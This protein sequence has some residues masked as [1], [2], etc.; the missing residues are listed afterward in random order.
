MVG[1]ART[2]RAVSLAVALGLA[3]PLISFAADPAAA[4][5]SQT[6]TVTGAA[7]PWTVPAGVTEIEVHAWGAQ[8]GGTYGGLGGYVRATMTVTPGEVLHVYVGGAGSDTSGAGGWNGGG[9]GAT[10][11]SP[12]GAGGGG[13]T[14]VRVTPHTLT[15]RAVV[16]GGGGGAAANAT[17]AFGA[18]GAGGGNDGGFGAA[19]T[20]GAA[21]GAPGTQMGGYQLGIGGSGWCNP[22]GGG[23]G[24]GYWGG[25]GGQDGS[26]FF[27]AGG[28]GGSGHVAPTEATPVRMLA[29]NRQGDGRVEIVWPP[30]PY[31]VP[32]SHTGSQAFTATS[33]SQYWIVP[34]D[35]TAITVEGWGA[36]GGGLH[37][38]L[39]GYAKATL[40]V[41]PGQTMQ[42]NV[43][44]AGLGDGTG[45]FNGGGAGG[46]NA[47]DPPGAGGGGA[48]D[49][50]FGGIT[51]EARQF[52]VGG[53]GGASGDANAVHGSGGV[54]GGIVGGDGAVGSPGSSDPGAG[55]GQLGGGAQGMGG[56]GAC[57]WS[58]PGGGGGGWFGGGGGE[59]F[60]APISSGGGGGSAYVAASTG[61]LIETLPGVRQG[62]GRI[63]LSWPP[64]PAVGVGAPAADSAAFAY[65]G[66]PSYWTVPAGVTAV[67]V[68]LWGA[69]G[70]GAHGGEGGH[71][72]A[73]VAVQ[74]GQ[75]LQVNV[76]GAGST[77]AGGWNGGGP[78]DHLGDPSVFPS[79]GGGA[80]DIRIGG[81]TLD[82]RHVV[83]GGGGGMAAGATSASGFGG[84]GGGISGG[85]GDPGS[86]GLVEPS[87]PGTQTSGWIPGQ[88]APNSVYC[89]D[90][91]GGAGGGGYWG[92]R[93][94]GEYGANIGA[95][96]GGGSGFV[97]PAAVGEQES[98]VR[99]GNGAA[100]ISW[101]VTLETAPTFG[102]DSYGEIV[103]G[104]HTGSGNVVESVVDVTIPT[105]GPT[106][107]MARTYNSL[108]TKVGPFGRGWTFGYETKLTDNGATVTVTNGDGR[109]DTF[110]LQPDGSYR[111]PYSYVLTLTDTGPGWRLQDKD[112]SAQLFDGAGRLTAIEDRYGRRVDL[113]YNVDEL[114]AVTDVASGRALSFEWTSGRIT[115]VRTSTVTVNGVTAQLLWRYAY[116]NGLLSK[117]CDARYPV[118]SGEKCTLYSYSNDRLS[119]I[120]TPRGN[121]ARAI[122]YYADGRVIW[123]D[124][125]VGKRHWFLYGAALTNV[126]DPALQIWSY[127]FDMRRRS[128]RT[129]DPMFHTTA[130]AYDIHGFRS[131]VIDANGNRVQMG[132]DARGNEISKTNGAEETTWMEYDANDRMI[133]RRDGRSANATDN[134]YKTSFTHNAQG[135]VLTETSPVTTEHPGGV[136]RTLTYTAGTENHG[137]GVVPAGLVLTAN[138]GDGTTQ[139]FYDSDGDL[140][141]QI[142][143]SGL[144]NE[145]DHDQLGRVTASRQIFN[146]Q[147]AETTTAYT[148]A[149]DV[150]AVTEP[151]V[152]N[153]IA[154]TAHR[155]TTANGYDPNRNLAV[156]I[157]HD[158][159]GSAAPTPLRFTVDTFD[160]ADRMSSTLDSA[161]KTTSRTFDPRGNVVTVT[162]P[163]G[164]VHTTTYDKA[165]RPLDTT[166]LSF[167]DDPITPGTPRNM[168]VSR[169]QHDRAGRLVAEMTP[170]PGTGGR[171][172]QLDPATTPMVVSR[173]AYDRADRITQRIAG[174]YNDLDGTLRNVVVTGATYDKAGNVVS[175]TAGGGLRVVNNTVDAMGRVQTQTLVSADGN[176]ISEFDYDK[177]GDRLRATTKNAA[178]AVVAETRSTYSTA[179]FL[180]SQTVE[181]G[182]D[183]LVTRYVY[184]QRGLQ[185][186]TLDPRSAGPTD[187]TYRT[188]VR[189]D[190]VGRPVETLRP[191]SEV[192]QANGTL[193]TLRERTRTGYDAVGNVVDT[194][195]PRGA[196]TH[197]TYDVL[198]RRTRI[199]HPSYTRPDAVTLTPFET[200]TYDDV[201]NLISRRD[202]R[203]HVTDFTFDKRNRVVR[204]LDPQLTG[205]SGR[206]ETR[207]EYDDAGNRV[208]TIDPIG[209]ESRTTHDDLGR[210][211]TQTAVVRQ[212]SG[213]PLSFTTTNDYD[214]LNNLRSVDDPTGVT[215]K[216]EYNAASQKTKTRDDANNQTKFEYDA[217]GRLLRTIDPLNRTVEHTY[218]LAGR[219]TATS[220][221]VSPTGAVLATS[222]TSYDKANNPFQ[223][224]DARATS[225]TDT[226][227]VTYTLF[228][229]TNRL[230][231]VL[232]PVDGT[233][234]NVWTQDYDIVG[235]IAR[236]TDGRPTP[237]VTTYRWS[238]WET[239]E[240][241]T[242]PGAIAYTTIYDNAGLPGVENQPGVTITRTFDELG[243]MN[244]EAGSGSG[245][246]SATNTFGYDRA[247]R[248]KS[249][250]HPDGTVSVT[251]DDRGLLTATTAP[252]TSTVA[253][254]FVYDPA[255]RMTSR[256]DAAGTSS[257]TYDPR[258]LLDVATDGVTGSTANFDW[259]TA[260][261]VAKVTYA[262]TPGATERN[263]V[264][265]AFGRLDTDTLKR[266][267]TIL[268]STDYGYDNAGNLTSQAIVAAANPAAGAHA[269]EYDRAGH[270]SRWTPPAPAPVVDYRYDPAG[271]RTQAGTETATYNTRNQILT[272]GTST[273]AWTARG[274]LDSVTT[275]GTPVDFD[276]D[277][278][279]RQITR[280]TTTFQYD[281]YGRSTTAGTTSF[282]HAGLE[283]D[284][285]RAGT[286]YYA[287]SPAGELLATTD[288]T[289]TRFVGENR[290]GDV[291]WLLSETA[292]VDATRIWDPYGKP[293]GT[294]GVTGLDVG[295]QG[296]WTD[297]TSG[298]VNMGQRWYDPNIGGFTARDTI[299][300]QLQ[301]PVS[302]NRY[303]YAQND[304][305]GM[306]DPDGRNPRI[307]D[308]PRNCPSPVKV[309]QL[310]RPSRPL[311]KNG[312]LTSS[313]TSIENKGP[314]RTQARRAEWAN[315]EHR[316]ITAPDPRQGQ[317]WVGESVEHEWSDG[318]H[319]AAMR[320]GYGLVIAAAIEIPALGVQRDITQKYRRE[321]G[322][323]IDKLVADYFDLCRYRA[324]DDCGGAEAL[325]RGGTRE[326]ARRLD[327]RNLGD[328]G[329]VR[330]DPVGQFVVE[331]V[332]TA[333]LMTGSKLAAKGAGR[334]VTREATRAAATETG[335]PAL[336]QAYV[337][338]VASISDNVA[339]WQKAGAD[340]E[341]IAREAWADR[342]A[343]G[344][345]YKN[346]TPPDV[347][348]QI[349]AR[350]LQRYGDPYGPTIEWLRTRNK[351]WEEIIESATRPGGQDLGF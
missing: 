7:Q 247:G 65:S 181:N 87:P 82:D 270:L 341:F 100:T 191:P 190:L 264:F 320:N 111:A 172:G 72:V 168:L 178:G 197:T 332:L 301:T 275:A 42:I 95:G 302:L 303:T 35:V 144:V 266:G 117:V 217:A 180:E 148:A 196:R 119:Q 294:N 36:Q 8:G 104:V 108:D 200:F 186:A 333:G 344:I 97:H 346:L 116:T 93:G 33:A 194:E 233:A 137:W 253:S 315:R 124:D 280:G 351:T 215:T 30:V 198:D 176:R 245:V 75:V 160:N 242:E 316:T 244:Q 319:V 282:E 243:R 62:D 99:A 163:L 231:A 279:G 138:D 337:D 4:A 164:R 120:T 15:N 38:G 287:R 177:T 19:G 78:P 295:Y 154:G 129:I 335:L 170:G 182:A 118:V 284:P 9:A 107:A 161:G 85:A 322:S 130:Y 159:G 109:R 336:R 313:I 236:V 25:L 314:A 199:D 268:T 114:A 207:F 103:A 310:H 296:D 235:Q 204:Q 32:P 84:F 142:G 169:K 83:A 165:N 91:C 23:G 55:G 56:D 327:A 237:G 66:S 80:T 174:D 212:P 185:T 227:Y 208:R 201:G 20:A 132:Y 146:S 262:T 18:G 218:D 211:R 123:T 158:T 230:Q 234:W 226:T 10:Q 151:L 206:G 331:T 258:G 90:N 44:A 74:P 291:S 345:Q 133:A 50:R 89:V 263:Y 43:G 274:T 143:P 325:L 213:G 3:V 307:C 79:G 101:P 340:P 261:Q 281:A 210:V 240:T 308:D 221:R 167:V 179:G 27:A 248:L 249:F 145:F 134:T 239:L 299:F 318:Y 122:G 187:T 157:V 328:L 102:A 76:G 1:R 288:G 98:G 222:W 24:G 252:G 49:I 26:G 209:A 86:S 251:N 14:D 193:A 224:S 330:D 171:A 343:L 183:D 173:L 125:G 225:L 70:G 113:T 47:K 257:F 21:T 88:G 150:A 228:D 152:T 147:T 81:T 203:G 323:E 39:G 219:Q 13:A 73:I 214:D 175:E 349:T 51:P 60:T 127:F 135:D 96:G 68:E 5:G 278:L 255:G 57:Y 29:G 34:A 22:C 28:G 220:Q 128:V 141:R 61:G 63:V 241:T 188:D 189:Y 329:G 321:Q 53:G 54:G 232:E 350:N 110:V 304:P 285:V 273:Y 71:A 348:E 334:L 271:N 259:N 166:L 277:A 11:F 17:L 162:D 276:F 126:I 41:E 260:G 195:T 52:V 267:S 300:G 297:P 40:S 338:E 184:D 289:N 202:R 45:G 311:V 312:R 131:A 112:R 77:T 229:A 342:R 339:A 256:T 155:K 16:A 149:G 293:A 140:R 272:Q 121:V 156:V 153:E 309:G 192:L 64:T 115:A 136:T 298:L 223:T 59:A 286:D 324:A 92:G 46:I 216:Y 94:G 246:V 31:T 58:C 139:S 290:H 106:V 12:P 69:Q 254:S 317:R 2:R 205:E 306:F 292:T 250:S 67:E 105:A 37:G 326:S 305:L 238:P 283:I 6:F 347:L 48:S 265:D 269:Y